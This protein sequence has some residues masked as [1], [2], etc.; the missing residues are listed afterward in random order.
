M[1]ILSQTFHIYNPISSSNNPMYYPNFSVQRIDS[2]RL[3]DL[4][5][6]TQLETGGISVKSLLHRL[7]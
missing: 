1:L 7:F 3:S 2:E 5:N 6:V 4:P